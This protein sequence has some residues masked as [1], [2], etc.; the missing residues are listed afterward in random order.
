MASLVMLL[1][2]FAEASDPEPSPT[3][4]AVS[5]DQ[6]VAIVTAPFWMSGSIE[7]GRAASA[8]MSTRAQG[9]RRRV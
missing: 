6:I 2:T 7:V 1:M 4:A 8:R 5:L 3:S 9:Q